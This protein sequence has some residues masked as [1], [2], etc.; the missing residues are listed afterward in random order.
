MYVYTAAGGVMLGYMLLKTELV[1]PA[2]SMLTLI[3]YPV[4]LLV[5]GMDLFG[6]TDTVNGVALIRLVPDASS[7]FFYRSGCSRRD[8][9]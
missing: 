5:S 1:P 6:A 3:G 9:T 8:S 7:N 2:S 4:L